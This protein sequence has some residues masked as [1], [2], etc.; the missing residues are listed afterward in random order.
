LR[1]LDVGTSPAGALAARLLAR[2]GAEVIKVE[3]P[4]VGDP[5]RRT[6]PFKKHAARGEAGALH[7]FVNEGKQ[8]ITLDLRSQT[9]RSIFDRLVAVSDVVMESL[10]Q[11]DVDA[12]RIN[13][14]TLAEAHPK[15][16]LTSITPFGRSGPYRDYRAGEFT[17]FAMGGHMYRTGTIG[18]PPIR[19]GGSPAFVLAALA[20]AYATLVAARTAA[21]EGYGQHV[22]FSILE[23][24]VTSHAQH[25]VEVSYYGEETGAKAPRQPA[26]GRRLF[27]RDGPVMFSVMEQQLPA[28]VEL[29]GAPSELAR[30][31]PGER[32]GTNPTLQT[33]VA[34]WVKDRMQQE[35]YE[36]GQAGHVPTSYTA[37]PAHLFD[38]PQYRHR[39]FLRSVQHA[40]AGAISVPGLPF[41]W[42]KP[43]P[44]MK[45]APML[46]QD[47]ERVYANLLQLS[48]EDLRRLFAAGVI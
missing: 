36:L 1:V 44:E 13:H 42:G 34:D 15:V 8:S 38:S 9:G 46:G 39:Q 32:V 14:A 7:L 17:T 41:R 10:Q 35:V 24:Q 11:N 48:G 6:G 27:A 4:G 43:E 28:L 31:T 37:S 40:E 2:L 5:T 30:P 20:A 26:E 19:M 33:Y 3:A 21:R 45:P 29:V 18:R 47:N 23:N 16:V 25:M 12:L 22:D